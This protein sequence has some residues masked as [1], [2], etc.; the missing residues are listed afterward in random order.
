LEDHLGLEL[1]VMFRY[2][3]LSNFTVNGPQQ[4]DGTVPVYGLVTMPD[5]FIGVADT[6]TINDTTQNR[7]L[8]MDLTGVEAALSLDYYFF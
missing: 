2:V 7:F 8:T 5:G 1:S 4:A 3:T 6:A